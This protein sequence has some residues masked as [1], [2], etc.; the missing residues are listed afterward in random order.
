MIK[1]ILAVAVALSVAACSTGP[2]TKFER[3][4]GTYSP[5]RET[6]GAGNNEGK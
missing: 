2:A 3:S 1:F 6:G 4:V 5:D